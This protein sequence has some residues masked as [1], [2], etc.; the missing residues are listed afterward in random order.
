MSTGPGRKFLDLWRQRVSPVG[1]SLLTL[2]WVLLWGDLS[3]G[4]VVAGL[5]L[6]LTILLLAPMP[7]GPQRRL[8]IR[9]IALARLMLVFAKDTAVAAAPIVWV[10]ITGRRPREAIIRVQ[11]RAHSDG[12]LA[13][14]AGFTALV[15]GSI[16]IDAHR[17]TGTLY[18]HVFDV[19]EGPEAMDE[20]HEQ[21]LRQEERILRALASDDELMTA[22]FR[23]GGS[24]KAGR[25]SETEMAEFRARQRAAGDTSGRSGPSSEVIA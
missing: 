1:A 21:V 19:D 4:N 13:A 3:W 18:I 23:P 20:A 14:T 17:M 11:T 6:A 2:M 8:T 12:F 22:G 9:P 24:M 5:A 16:V 10:I 15:P 7:H 25:L